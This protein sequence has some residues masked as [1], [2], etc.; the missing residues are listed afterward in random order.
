VLG[1]LRQRINDG[2]YAEHDQ[3]PPEDRLAA[4][5]GVS[6]ATIRQAVGELVR[7]GLVDRRQ[8]LFVKTWYRADLYEYRVTFQADRGQH[9]VKLRVV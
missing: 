6:R 4:E 3:L 8:G 1:V 2:V 9:G 5:F 7:H